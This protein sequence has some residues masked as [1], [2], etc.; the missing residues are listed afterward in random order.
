[1]K[2]MIA[3]GDGGVDIVESRGDTIVYGGDRNYGDILVLIVLAVVVIYDDNDHV[4]LYSARHA[5]TRPHCRVARDSSHDL[6]LFLLLGLSPH[7]FFS[8]CILLHPLRIIQPGRTVLTLRPRLG[9]V[10][11]AVVVAALLPDVSRAAAN[12]CSGSP[13]HTAVITLF[14]ASILNPFSSHF[15]VTQW[16]TVIAGVP[17]LNASPPPFHGNCSY[18]RN[19]PNQF[20]S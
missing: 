17:S 12:P 15:T 1:M 4:R 6:H 10:K 18:S 7:P 11:A 13:V 3:S 16:F 2:M 9:V 5:V 20:V 8:P 14:V 19:Y